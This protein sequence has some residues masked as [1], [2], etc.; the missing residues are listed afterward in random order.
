[1]TLDRELMLMV[2]PFVEVSIPLIA[3]SAPL[4]PLWASLAVEE[5]LLLSFSRSFSALEVS[6]LV[7]I[8]I[9]S[10]AIHLV[11]FYESS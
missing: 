5:S 7:S 10:S 2:S 8:L 3:V 11:S 4:N 1:M 9:A 6:I